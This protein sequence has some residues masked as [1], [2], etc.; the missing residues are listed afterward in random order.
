MHIPVFLTLL[1]YNKK[2]TNLGNDIYTDD[3]KTLL[4]QLSLGNLGFSSTECNLQPMAYGGENLAKLKCK[5]G[6]L[7]TLVDFGITT[8]AED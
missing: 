1:S 8:K 2:Y 3:D 7:T 6:V 5:T 4:E